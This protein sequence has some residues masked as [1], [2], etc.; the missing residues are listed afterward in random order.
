MHVGVMLLRMKRK[1]FVIIC[2][3]AISCVLLF[4][5][6]PSQDGNSGGSY[7]SWVAGNTKDSVVQVVT[8]K[9]VVVPFEVRVGSAV[10]E[11]RFEIKDE[12][13]RMKGIFL[14]DTVVPVR[15]GMAS[16][17]VIFNFQSGAG[18]KAGCYALTIIARDTV[19]GKIIREGK[20]PFAV[21]M[22]D[23]IWKCSC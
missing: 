8:G 2:T 18:M 3:L 10:S 19:S 4:V 7:F 6:K 15:K 21:D 11:M 23:L 9:P 13:Q 20:I 5:W 17:R 14:E 16:S 12:S 1:T 22:L